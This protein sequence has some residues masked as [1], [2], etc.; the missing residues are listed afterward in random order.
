[1]PSLSASVCSDCMVPRP[2]RISIPTSDRFTPSFGFARADLPRDPLD[3]RLEAEPG[4]HAHDEDIH[5]VGE[6]VAV[7]L[8]QASAGGTR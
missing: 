1:M 6:A 5:H 4:V 3:R 8:L 2:A 7:F